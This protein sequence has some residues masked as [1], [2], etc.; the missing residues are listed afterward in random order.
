MKK[1]NP[2]SWRNDAY[3]K[4]TGRTKYTDDIKFPFM[5]HAVPVYT[6]SVHAV[7]KSIDTSAAEEST[8]VV[9]CFSWVGGYGGG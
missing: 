9:Y 5:L 6:D 2:K 3:A 1:E 7:I 8:G 4:V